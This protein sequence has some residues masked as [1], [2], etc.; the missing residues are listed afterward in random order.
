MSKKSIL[1]YLVEIIETKMEYA[2]YLLFS[3]T[4]KGVDEK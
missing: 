4:N 1:D 3:S 2:E